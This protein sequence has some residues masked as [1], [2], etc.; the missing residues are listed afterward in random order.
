MLLLAGGGF[1]WLLCSREGADSN[2][3][4][5]RLIQAQSAKGVSA[6]G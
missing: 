2:N 4:A 5:R 1:D 3:L 6:I